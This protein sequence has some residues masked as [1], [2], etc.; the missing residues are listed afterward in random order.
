MRHVRQEARRRH[1]G[2]DELATALADWFAEHEREETSG[3]ERDVRGF[4][5]IHPLW[6]EEPDSATFLRGNGRDESA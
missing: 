6:R 1:P 5:Q 3:Y 2:S 4:G